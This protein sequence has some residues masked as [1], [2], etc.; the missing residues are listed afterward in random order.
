MARFRATLDVDGPVQEVWDRL[1]DWPAHS[2]WVPFT[3]VRVLTASGQGVGARFNGRTGVGPLGFDDP[4]EVT[5][6]QPPTGG[7]AGRCEVVK[8]GGFVTGSAGFDV[9]PLGESRSRVVWD[10]EV[11]VPPRLLTRRLA[12]PLGWAG[13]V[14]FTRALRAM[15][16]ELR[17]ERRG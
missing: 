7:A 9:V 14:A 4:M 2:R 16:A 1:T 11:E 3:R 17:R 15:A 13:R 5:L 8:L 10:E 6:W 12:A